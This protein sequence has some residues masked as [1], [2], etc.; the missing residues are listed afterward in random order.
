MKLLFYFTFCFVSLFGTF[1]Q[2][3]TLCKKFT[4]EFTV[5][6]VGSK[7]GEFAFSLSNAFNNACVIMA[8]DNNP[9]ARSLANALLKK[10]T[11]SKKANT[12]MLVMRRLTDTDIRTMSSCCYFDVV[13]ILGE[14]SYTGRQA[15]CFDIDMYAKNLLTLGAHTFIEA[16]EG[17][18]FSHA[19]EKLSPSKCY[20]D[21]SSILFYF[22]NE[23]A[24]LTRAHFFAPEKERVIVADFEQRVE[25]FRGQSPFKTVILQARAGLSLLDFKALS[26][27]FPTAGDLEKFYR[28]LHLCSKKS[29][30][31]HEIYVTAKGLQLNAPYHVIETD[32]PCDKD[33]VRAII[34]AT[35]KGE[36]EAL[37]KD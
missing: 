35:S 33:F 28:E 6:D 19:L 7:D 13:T 31:P 15:F 24:V 14:T 16:A 5:L 17:S 36:I 20:R 27:G 32:R 30:Y 12:P 8:E 22:V 26:G 29:I 10:C 4:R 11:S 1:E 25:V 23:R 9:Q 18:D 2:I 37:L 34:H 21:G 3:H